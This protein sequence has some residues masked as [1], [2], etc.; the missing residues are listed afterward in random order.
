SRPL[1]NGLILLQVTHPEKEDISI[2]T[3]ALNDINSGKKQRILFLVKK[4]IWQK[5]LDPKNP[6][7]KRLKLKFEREQT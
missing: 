1:K 4:D 3:I 6:C 2:K 7:F 5:Y